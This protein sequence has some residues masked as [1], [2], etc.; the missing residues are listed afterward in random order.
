M[1]ANGT[2]FH[3]VLNRDEW[4][5]PDMPVGLDWSD[6]SHTLSLAPR[7]FVFPAQGASS[8]PAVDDRRGAARDRYGNWYWIGPNRDEIRFRGACAARSEHFWSAADERNRRPTTEDDARDF[9]PPAAAP[10]TVVMSGLAVTSDHFLVVGL[11]SPAGVLIFDLHATGAPFEIDWPSE[12]PFEPFDIAAAVD[13]GAW[14]LDRHNGMVWRVDRHF[15]VRAERAVAPLAPA[16]A[17]FADVVPGARCDTGLRPWCGR[18]LADRAIPL[19]FDGAIAIET[20]PD[21]SLLILQ[22]DPAAT[23]SVIHRYRGGQF[24]GALDLRHALEGRLAAGAGG[25]TGGSDDGIAGYD[26]AFV[27]DADATK[28]AVKGTLY[29]V[30]RGGNQAF[31]FAI[32]ETVAAAS[33]PA[34]A[35][36]VFSLQPQYVPLRL[37]G[38]KA[39][40]ASGGAAYYDIEDRW[41][42]LAVQPRPRFAVE[43]T[44]TLPPPGGECSV[45]DGGEPGC[46]W[47]RVFVDACIPPDCELAIESRAAD[48][49]DL[50]AQDLVAWR[51]EPRPYLRGTGAEIPYYQPTLPGSPDRTGTWESLLQ[52]AVGRYLQ[53]RL[54]MRGSGRSTPRLQAL[55]VY[56]PRF[57]Y[58]RQYLPAVY[59]EDPGSASFLD[60][61]LANV[62]GFYTDVEGRI[63]ESRALFDTRLIAPE[64]LEWLAAWLSATLDAGWPGDR[65]RFFLAHAWRM[66]AERGTVPGIVRAVRLTLDD[67]IDESLF[68]QNAPGPA[69]TV[70]VAE[71]FMTRPESGVDLSEPADTGQLLLV[72][73]SDAW[74]PQQGAG[75]LHEKYRA[76]LRAR[77]DTLDALNAAWDAGYGSFDEIRFTVGPV[78]E[79]R[80]A[81]DWQR[82]AGGALG[83]TCVAPQSSDVQWFR[84]FLA[85]RYR[86]IAELRRRYDLPA[87]AGPAS[88]A[89]IALPADLP[90]GGAPL[91]DWI[92]FVSVFLPMRRSAYRFKVLVP[93]SPSEPQRAQQVKLE[94]ARRVAA[95]EKPAHTDFDVGLYWALFRVG[96]CRLGE[97]TLLGESSRVVSL[98]LGATPLGDGFLN[99]SHPWDVGD[100]MIAGRERFGGDPTGATPPTLE[101]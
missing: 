13:G 39:L 23:W 94:M 35:G 9:S 49:E 4:C 73:R 67:C 45:F 20:L 43:A 59:R 26:L 92:E 77:Y 32:D 60:R 12:V 48:R 72:P 66:F 57:S 11:A 40:V 50:L 53:L 68:D 81:A 21:D 95:R 3:L 2:R 58:L 18:V 44:C 79:R 98:E 85:V 41:A 25:R 91:R 71:T 82:F 93:V 31:A 80:R 33:S 1:D 89:D 14:I 78:G 61:L 63:E 46:V 90:D 37:F 99:P 15:R 42:R 7:W 84:D 8:P 75:T 38:G 69:F 6:A 96:Q 30:A 87:D 10:R 36:A 76:F 83:F 74:G 17:D 65:R 51:S 64:Y 28:G 19:P 100:R 55:R 27:A 34:A 5:G 22:S 88:F 56:Y 70:R 52:E 24:A 97:D 54:T 29:L 16:P 47:H 101:H 62:E 86:H